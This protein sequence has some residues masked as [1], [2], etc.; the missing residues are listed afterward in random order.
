MHLA[1]GVDADVGR[2]FLIAI[3]AIIEI[4]LRAGI[5][6]CELET[7]SQHL[8]HQKAG[9]DGLEIIVD[10]VDHQRVVGGRFRDQIGKPRPR[11]ARRIAGGAAD[12]LDDFRK[13]GAIAHRQCMFTPDPVETFL[14]HAQR[15]NHVN[16]IAIAARRG[17]FQRGHHAIPLGS[18]IV[19]QVRDLDCGA[20]GCLEQMKAGLRINPVP[21]TQMA[22][23]VLC[24]AVLVLQALARINRW[25]VDDGLDRRVEQGRDLLGVGAG[26]E[27]VADVQHLEVLIAVELLV[28]GIGDRL[29]L[30]FVIGCQHG[31][32]VAPEITAGHGHDMRLVAPDQ[33]GELRA[34][35][36][37]GVGGDMVE[38]VD[39]DERGVE[40]F[41][42]QLVKG[43]AESRM[44]TNQ[45][46]GIAGQKFADSLDLGL[47]HLRVIGAGRVAQVPLRCDFPVGPKAMLA[48]R[49]A[50]ETGA[51]RAFRHA[52]DG[53]LN[54]LVGQLVQRDEHQRA[55]LA[56]GRG[57]LDQQILLATL[58]IGPRLHRAHPQLVRLG[59]RASPGGAEGDGGDDVGILGHLNNSLWVPARTKTS[60]PPGPAVSSTS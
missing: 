48:Q 14:G 35:A 50:V 28:I 53:L 46:P 33:L 16:E 20:A 51:D 26:V 40:S 43:K 6:G 55:R 15:D 3:G 56:R 58:V 27:A 37:A 8:F 24:L 23:D 25:N 22:H 32:G 10:G 13:A 11:L 36:V 34:Q 12:D 7:R 57:R 19:D 17:G 31:D 59:S 52:D 1:L 18:I 21:F 29:E 45:H 9:G 4:R 38:F 30:G 39:G 44:C 60:V 5:L 47:G 42:P 49:L 41:N 2:P 54:A